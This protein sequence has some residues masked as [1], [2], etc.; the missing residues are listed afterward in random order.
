MNMYFFYNEG[1]KKYFN[2]TN[3]LIV[4]INTRQLKL[5][6]RGVGAVGRGDRGRRGERNH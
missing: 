4:R 1:K 3:P 5:E 2:K 6:G